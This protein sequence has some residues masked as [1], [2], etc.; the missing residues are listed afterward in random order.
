MKS[1]DGLA[2]NTVLPARVGVGIVS[3]ADAQTRTQAVDL[4][5]EG[6]SLPRQIWVTA[7]DERSA[8]GFL[9]IENGLAHGVLL[10]FKHI[11]EVSGKIRRF[12]N[13]SA[14]YVRPSHRAY[15]FRLF[16]AAIA[17]KDVIYTCVT[18]GPTPI[19]IAVANGF[20]IIS[21]GSILSVPLLN[22]LGLGKGIRIKAYKDKIAC[23]VDA[24][25]RK[26]LEDHDDERHVIILISGLGPTFPAILRKTRDRRGIYYARLS[27]V[28]NHERM[29]AALPALHWYLLIRKAIVGI[30]F[31]RIPPYGGLRSVIAAPRGPSILIKG[32]IPDGDID[33][34]Y[35]EM[36]YVPTL[37]MMG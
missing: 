3:I 26:L 37:R 8:S 16:H 23:D 14:W 22:G 13:L 27:Y 17:E 36:L 1:G 9:L 12:I 21:N 19:K 18:P 24:E 30:Q 33:L 11:R 2:H 34:L 35:T 32:D 10:T 7:L 31:P 25:T 6:F 28:R 5:T 15:S 4:L 20:R 29:C